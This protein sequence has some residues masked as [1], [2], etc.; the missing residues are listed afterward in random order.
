MARKHPQTSYAP[1]AM[2]LALPPEGVAFL[3]REETRALATRLQSLANDPLR[4][5][6]QLAG[7][8]DP[9]E[10]RWFMDY[11]QLVP[12]IQEKLGL[13]VWPVCDR[14]AL[15]QS[16]AQD[17][18]RW[19]AALWPRQ[20]TLHDLCCGMGGDSFFIPSDIHVEGYD[21]DPARLA[22]FDF[23]MES[24]GLPRRATLQDVR[25][26]ESSADFFCIDPARRAEL[27]Q[28]QRNL[29]HL[30]P[31]LDE[32]LAL[33]AKYGGG[34]VKLPPGYPTENLPPSAEILYVGGR[35][36]CREC[37]LLLGNLATRPGRVRAVCLEENV[38]EWEGEP[39]QTQEGLG[40][41]DP[42]RYLFEPLPVLVR[43]HLFIAVGRKA[44]LWQ[45]DAGLAYLSGDTLPPPDAGLV[46][47][48][49]IEHCP[50]TTSG[51]QQM[52][53][54][55]DIGKLTLKKRG[56][57]VIPEDEIRRLDPRGSQSAIL[58]YTRLRGE[59][60]A[61]LAQKMVIIP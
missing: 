14:L 11:L 18:G 37:L 61:V 13:P 1:P 8:M 40:V 24:L 41:A 26:L 36:D 10:R 16:T 47:Y 9:T 55:H 45:I 7:R 20:S 52:L 43:S 29:T 35:T 42:G 30:T 27:G 51:V 46:P 53:R 44:G 5:A 33:A 49:V 58:F 3:C 2:P 4:L 32:V 34:M 23:N 19:K 22:M 17:L 21:L 57:E 15:E 6:S 31:T 56:V 50:L 59:K 54:R 60:S 12:R 38:R 25:S 28:N 48:E 39:A